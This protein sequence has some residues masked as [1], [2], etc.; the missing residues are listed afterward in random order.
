MIDKLPF[1]WQVM[2]VSTVLTLSY[3]L[4]L[5][6]G[7]LMGQD[8]FGTIFSMLVIAGGFF[9]TLYACD[10]YGYAVH[11][12]QQSVMVGTAGAI[13]ITLFVA[14]LRAGLARL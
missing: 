11:G 3:P 12:L 9:G 4:S 2:A 13:G 7:S 5:V 1:F 14:F 10:H 8:R 6:I